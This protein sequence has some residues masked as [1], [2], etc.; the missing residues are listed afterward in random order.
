MIQ[1]PPIADV[2]VEPYFARVGYVEFSAATTGVQNYGLDLD[3]EI[4]RDTATKTL[5]PSRYSTGDFVAGVIHKNQ[6]NLGSVSV[7]HVS[8]AG[9]YGTEVGNNTSENTTV[10]MT[11]AEA[12]TAVGA[13]G[14]VAALPESQTWIDEWDSH[15]VE[16]WVNTTDGPGVTGATVDLAYNSQYFT[17]TEID[18]GPIFVDRASGS[19]DD[20]VGLAASIGG[21]TTRTDVGG[22]GYALL[23]RVKFESLSND[24]VPVDKS[25][26]FIGPY[27]LGLALSEAQLEVPG[28]GVVNPTMGQTP[29]T[30]LWAIPY[31]V[32]DSDRID[33]GDFTFLATDFA[34]NVFDSDSP[35]VWAMDFDKSG[36]LDFGDFSFFALNFAGEKGVD[37][38]IRFPGSFMQRW[39][40]SVGDLDGTVSLGELLD[41]A[42]ETWQDVLGLAEPINV[43][44]VVHDFG[45]AQLQ[46]SGHR[47]SL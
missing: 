18:H 38:D 45:D 46:I 5:S 9:L 4:D 47:A 1:V 17:A 11:L 7:T 35:Y 29:T 12:P 36:T 10:C 3:S 33:F 8:G 30:E 40:G 25:N 21:A 20:V 43:Q 24:Q 6:V 37:L 34:Q 26:L 15:W 16:F 13:D 19:I 32:D 23:G 27:D 22:T 2:G 41:A 39:I 28:V 31:D 44:L 42:T 14:H